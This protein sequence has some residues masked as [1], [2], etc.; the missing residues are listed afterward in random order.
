MAKRAQQESGEE[1]LK[2]EAIAQ[3]SPFTMQPDPQEE[4]RLF[5]ARIAQMEKQGSMEDG[6]PRC[7]PH[8]LSF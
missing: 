5:R 1:A 7:V 6:D 4:I 8:F 2:A 3:P